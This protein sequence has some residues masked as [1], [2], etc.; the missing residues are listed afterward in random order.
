MKQLLVSI[1]S[2][3]VLF[4]SPSIAAG[5]DTQYVMVYSLIQEGDQ[6]MRSG[7]SESA[8]VKY[9]E[10][11]GELQKMQVAF[12][13]W[14]AGVVKFRLSYVNG[15]LAELGPEPSAAKTAEGSE[16]SAG[17]PQPDDRPSQADAANEEVR[18]LR[19]E[20]SVLESKLKEALA[21][22]PAALNP[23]ELAK[24]EEKIRMLEKEKELLRL[25]L[26]EEKAKKGSEGGDRFAAA[27]AEA[28][29]KI[30][31]QAEAIVALRREKEILET[32]LLAASQGSESVRE[33][34][35]E[36]QELKDQ[37][38]PVEAAPPT[39]QRAP[40]PTSGAKD[41]SDAALNEAEVGRLQTALGTLQEEKA[42]LEKVKANL[43]VELAAATADPASQA[44]RVRQGE[45]ERDELLK[46][47]NETTRQLYDNKAQTEMVEKRQTASQLEILRARLEV[48]EARKVPFTTEELA[49]FRKPDLELGKAGSS[50]GRRTLLE[51]PK[52]AGPLIVEAERAFAARRFD[53]AAVKFREILKLDS[54]S[55]YAL[56]NLATIDL[57]QNRLTDAE[58]NLNRALG[59]DPNDP[60]TLTL[61]GSLK[62]S[63]QKYEEALNV[64]GRAAQIDPNDPETQNYLGI[65]L[66]HLE[67][68]GPA[69]TALRRAIQ[70]APNFG[71]A[72]QNLAII[73]A[74]QQPPFRELA[75]WHYQ[76]SL[77][78][79]HPANPEV[80]KLI[81]RDTGGIRAE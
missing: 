9:V 4:V 55:V 51:P 64:L 20:N 15:R 78:T 72:H 67:Q 43:E 69:E 39:I 75:R 17:R 71:G 11:Q 23:Q 65:T 14:N 16:P 80:E 38:A 57:H 48:F 40:A 1:L 27:F 19:I 30:S 28:N 10:A 70:L 6:F 41:I 5:P 44:N 81:E 8:R 21:A 7:Q 52:G 34:R 49:L 3:F 54:K 37:R 26:E 76:K 46:K 47:L 53:E 36:S 29:R 73:Y 32:R 18:R 60:H 61:L 66:S 31:E 35:V 62:F 45:V 25:A 63:Q 74:T 77:A 33:L 42:E 59:F 79:G 50:G 68:R 22:R 2:L 24:A 13:T 12:P 58:A 56:A